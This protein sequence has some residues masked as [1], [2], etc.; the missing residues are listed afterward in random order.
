MLKRPGSRSHSFPEG[1]GTTCCVHMGRFS[2][3]RWSFMSVVGDTPLCSSCPGR[4]EGEEGERMRRLMRRQGSRGQ[5]LRSKSHCLLSPGLLPLSVS[6]IHSANAGWVC[7]PCQVLFQVLEVA[8]HPRL[9]RTY[10]LV[11]GHHQSYF[12]PSPPADLDILP[13]GFSVLSLS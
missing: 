4:G 10:V 2:L 3:G 7:A 5:G 13:S 12:S 6:L 9:P 1:G 11:G 8:Q